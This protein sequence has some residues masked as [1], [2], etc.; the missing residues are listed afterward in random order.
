[1]KKYLLFL[2]TF[3]LL[4][5]CAVSLEDEKCDAYLENAIVALEGKDTD[6]FVDL[7][8]E[9][10][11]EENSRE[12]MEIAIGDM[13]SM[14]QGH[15]VSY[16]MQSKTV[17]RRIDFK[18]YIQCV[19]KVTTTEAEYNVTIIRVEGTAGLDEMAWFNLQRNL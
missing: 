16:E 15:V 18:T 11:L 19:Y 12:D 9:K 14:W 7:F 1:M 13:I 10:A 5:G 4:T 17:K 8:W 2:I 6:A 3:L